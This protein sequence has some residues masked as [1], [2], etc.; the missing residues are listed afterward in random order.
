[1]TQY[2]FFVYGTLRPGLGNYSWALDGRTTREE[3][4]RVQGLSMFLGVGFPYATY[5]RPE[6][7]AEATTVIGEVVWVSED[8]YGDVL[9]SLDH[10]EGYRGAGKSNHYE[11]VLIK[12]EVNGE[13]V[14]A[15]TYVASDGQSDF[16]WHKYQPWDEGDWK[17]AIK[18]VPGLMGF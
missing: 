13:M 1:M 3:S 11:R 7:N 8:E 18:A 16:L 4:A 17:A 15:Y 10:L 6:R 12:A 14:E 9:A 2:P 5:A